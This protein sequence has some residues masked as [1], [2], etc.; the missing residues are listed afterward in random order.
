MEQLCSSARGLRATSSCPSALFDVSRD[1]S[2][3]VTSKSPADALTET[4]R[5]PPGELALK[6]L[7]QALGLAA[8]LKH[9]RLQSL[10]LDLHT[11]TQHSKGSRTSHAES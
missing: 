11:A 1:V 8:T 7:D 3:R 10:K 6:L 4:F 2:S 9:R 5:P